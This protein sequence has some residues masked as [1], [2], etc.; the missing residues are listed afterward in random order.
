MNNKSPLYGFMSIIILFICCPLSMAGENSLVAGVDCSI[1]VLGALRDPFVSKSF[2][3][4]DTSAGAVAVNAGV[5]PAIINKETRMSSSGDIAPVSPSSRNIARKADGGVASPRE[6][7]FHL[8]LTGIIFDTAKPKAI[9]NGKIVGIGDTID[10]VV[11]SN[12][13][14]GA[15]EI[16]RGNLISNLNMN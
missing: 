5:A 12:I 14:K 3:P 4:A 9:I 11:I 7:E 1:E 13:R 16:R 6:G 10:G 8:E 2:T 15:V